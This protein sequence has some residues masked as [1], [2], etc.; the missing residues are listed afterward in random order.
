MSISSLNILSLCP[1]C[2]NYPLLSLFNDQ[3]KDILIL[4][5]HCGYKA[6]TSL[7]NYLNQ[8]KNLQK[9]KVKSKNYTN[10]NRLFHKYCITCKS[11]SCNKNTDSELHKLIVLDNII[12]TININ[13]QLSEGYNHINIYCNQ[14]KNKNID[15]YLTKINQ[16][17][18]SYQSFKSMNND[19][20]NI[21]SIMINNY[22]KNH[23]NF[24][25]RQ[26]INNIINS[27]KLNLEKCNNNKDT[28]LINYY[29]NYNILGKIID[30]NHIKTIKEHCYGVT[31]LLILS[32]GRLASCSFDKTI[33]IY[34]MKNNY[35][36]D[37]TIT[38]HTGSVKYISQLDNNK[39]ISCSYDISIKI[40]SITQ[41]SYQ[42]NHTFKKAHSSGIWKVI[43]LT[44]NRI[45]S[46]SIDKT[47]KIWNSRHPY[48]LIWTFNDNTRFTSIIQIKNKDILISGGL[49]K[50]LYKWNLSTYQ[51]ESKIKDVQCYDSNSLLE[52]ENNRII[53]G[54]LKEISIVNIFN[55]SIEHQITNDKLSIV[56][57]LIQLRDG[58]ILCGCSDGLMCVY[59]I[60]S[61]TL[62]FKADK[63]HD[64]HVSCLVNINKYQFISGSFD[65]TIKVWKY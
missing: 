4:C 26:N 62:S 31:F 47:I 9:I 43:Q 27:Y 20:L 18:Y 12:S 42:C 35:H 32:D 63:M 23:Y 25:F 14:L 59:D 11:Y 2:N 24:Y 1:Q 61:N 34:N 29:N 36:C 6:Y 60:K 38:G 19:I 41:K 40:W 44:G 22:N 58:N 51:C 39:L 57:S 45:A 52:L 10:H 30:I 53:V 7:H 5:E 56:S 37:I 15:N 64:D 55:D 50:M 17:E 3:P 49:E 16:L 48:N 46:C 28:E 8:M 54:G 65:K 33:K 13:E 21:I